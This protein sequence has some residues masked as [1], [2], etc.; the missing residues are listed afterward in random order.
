[1][2]FWATLEHKLHYKKNLGKE[3]EKTFSEELRKCAEESIRLDLKMQD[4][5]NRIEKRK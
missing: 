4:I 3:M 2:D 5:Q 1:M